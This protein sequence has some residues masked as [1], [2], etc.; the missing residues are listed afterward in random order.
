MNR[1]KRIA[2]TGLIALSLAGSVEA[3]DPKNTVVAYWQQ[4]WPKQ[5]VANQQIQDINASF[6]TNFPTWKDRVNGN[7]GVIFL[8]DVTRNFRA[9]AQF[10]YSQGSISGEEIIQT[11]AGPARATF[12]Q[13]Y[14]Y[15]LDLLG[16]GQWH[17]KPDTRFDPFL[18]GAAGIAYEKDNASLRIANENLNEDLFAKTSATLPI[19]SIGGGVDVELKG[20][21]L[22]FTGG[23]SWAHTSKTIPAQGSL[24]PGNVTADT[25]LTGPNYTIGIGKRW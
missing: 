21:I 16:M 11:P 24:S 18:Y 19:A 12:K 14:D 1:L 3:Q 6:S 2:L 7:I 9:G 8:R 5:T 17:F 15:Y 20:I 4:N 13:S 25:D 10:D 23:Y 22:E